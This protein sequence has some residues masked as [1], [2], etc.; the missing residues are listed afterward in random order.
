MP[1]GRLREDAVKVALASCEFPMVQWTIEPE[2]NRIWINEGVR[3]TQE[4][5]YIDIVKQVPGDAKQG[6]PFRIRIP[7]RFNR[8]R[9]AVVK[10]G[11]VHV[12][13]EF[14]HGF[15]DQEMK[16]VRIIGG[17]G[18]DIPVSTLRVETDTCFSMFVVAGLIHFIDSAC[19]IYVPTIPS[20]G[21]LCAFLTN[22]S[23]F[24]SGLRL[25]FR[26][27][28][29]NDKVNVTG[30]VDVINT[31]CQILPSPLAHMCGLSTTPLR[32]ETNS[33]NWPCESTHLWDYAEIQ[34]GFY[35]P[36]HR[37]MCVGQPLRFGTELEMAVNR[38][39]FPLGGGNA[40]SGDAKGDHLLVFTDPNG[41]NLTCTIPPGRYSAITLSRLLEDEM[42]S[43]ARQF[44][45]KISFSVQHNEKN[46]F[47][48][49]CERQN[50]GGY[51]PANFSLLFHHPFCIDPTRIGFSTQ[52]LSGSHTYVAPIST[53]PTCVESK[54]SR[55]VSNLL[56]VGDISSQKRFRIHATPVPAI[57][58]VVID[59]NP[60][61]SDNKILSVS[62]F[63]NGIP[64]A[65]GF[66]L[67]DTVCI[68]SQSAQIVCI[69]GVDME[70]MDTTASLPQECT[71]IVDSS[72]NP[73]VLN[74]IPPYLSE[75]WNTGSCIRIL[76]EVQPFNI[77]FC[78][79]VSIP[80]HL[81]GFRKGVVQWGIDGSISDDNGQFI[82]PFEAPNSHCL[83]HP[84]YVLM[85]FSESSGV[86]FEHSFNGESKHIFCKLSLYPLFREERMLP[87]D[88][89][90]LKN[91]LSRFTLSFWNPDMHTPYKFHGAE[92]SFSLNFVSSIPSMEQI[93]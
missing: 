71:C 24:M 48:F 8:V 92:F 23:K 80:P 4:N 45:N 56:R 36:C 89:T 41:N 77:N 81:M 37:P 49:S 78:K 82:P 60:S 66:Q 25:T 46:K 61:T 34:P 27:D 12:E 35:S 53:R 11:R 74:L 93:G 7:P 33:V 57:L 64:F 62:T 1:S 70:V 29:A 86:Q 68:L 52:P 9:K 32:F 39:Y 54:G 15:F 58:G 79:P 40:T 90:L 43:T 16:D 20:P 72:Q 30:C 5:N 59:Q 65:H 42:T 38:L 10:T 3:L 73:C 26:Y 50:Q 13:C 91:N 47:V 22:G 2:W 67:N 76:G 31:V 14:E 87:R 28:T 44:D 6:S 84:D 18:G 21:K 17:I 69:K 85:T 63:V 75:L 83:D 88:T 51:S 19:T 55:V